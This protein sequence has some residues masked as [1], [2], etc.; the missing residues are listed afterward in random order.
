MAPGPVVTAGVF[1]AGAAAFVRKRTVDNSQVQLIHAPTTASVEGA[2]TL[3]DI[4]I[5]ECPSLADPVK[6]RFVPSALLPTADFQ[7][8]FNGVKERFA[9]P[10]MVSYERELITTKDGGTI[11]LDWTPPFAEMPEDDRPI[12]IL[13]HGL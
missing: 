4:V 7:T 10:R 13:S 12:V 11:G 8:C 1:A 6:G 9:K 3:A 2:K 5:A